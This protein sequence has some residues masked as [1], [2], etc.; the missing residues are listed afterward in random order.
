[1]LAAASAHLSS[2]GQPDMLTVHFEYPSQAAVGPA[3]VV[4]EDVKL[5]RRLSILHLTLRQGG[6]VEQAPWITSYISR[7]VV[8][9]YTT[10]TNL[11]TA[12]GMS[13][14]TGYEATAA[15][16][17]PPPPDFETLKLKGA[18]ECWKQSK[19][20]KVLA[21]WRSLC[22]WCFYLPRGGQLA[23]GTLDM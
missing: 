6:L 4:I 14:R 13:V 7:R 20:P 22:N 19:L 11:R 2:R 18:D 8:L 3:I 23:P 5:A 21:S 9:A 15:T 12:T 16:A 17:L 10:Y 1:M